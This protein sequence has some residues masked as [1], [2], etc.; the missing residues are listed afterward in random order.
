MKIADVAHV[1]RFTRATDNRI[2]HDGPYIGTHT[3]MGLPIVTVASYR[4]D[5]VGGSDGTL[6][7]HPQTLWALY[8]AVTTGREMDDPHVQLDAALAA[9]RDTLQ[10]REASAVVRMQDMARAF[11]LRADHY[12]RIRWCEMERYPHAYVQWTTKH[13]Q[14]N[15]WECFDCGMEA[16]AES[17]AS[18]GVKL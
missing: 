17:L 3:F 2:S 9:L 7:M 13:Y 16:T 18:A 5:A 12:Y 10:N 8:L 6:Y 4:L 1:A 11:A 14:L 15:T